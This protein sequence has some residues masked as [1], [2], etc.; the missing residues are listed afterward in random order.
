MWRCTKTGHIWG[1]HGWPK[2]TFL[3]KWRNYPKHLSYS[4]FNI[5]QKKGFFLTMFNKIVELVFWGI[6]L[7]PTGAMAHLLEKVNIFVTHPWNNLRSAHFSWQTNT[8]FFVTDG[9]PNWPFRCLDMKSFLFLGK[10]QKRILTQ[11]EKV[12]IFVTIR[13]HGGSN[14]PFRCSDISIFWGQIEVGDWNVVTIYR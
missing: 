10:E 8:H 6:P 11:L 7:I 12:F 9:G 4:F 5:V 3:R 13:T 14:S 1:M 2:L